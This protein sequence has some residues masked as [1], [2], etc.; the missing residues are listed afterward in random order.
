MNSAAG[1]STQLQREVRFGDVRFDFYVCRGEGSRLEL[2]SRLATL[3]ADRFVLVVDE[4]LPAAAVA[5]VESNLGAIAPTL[6]VTVA[7]HEQTKRLATIDA[8]AERAILAGVTRRSCIV[9]LGGGVVGNMAGLLAGL[10]YRGVRL[11]HLPTT[12]LAMSDSVLSAKQAVNSREG[13]NH[14]G[15]F[16]PPVL[17]WNQLELLDSLP[18]EEIQSALC[19]LIKNVLCICPDRYDEVAVRLRPDACYPA[20]VIIDFIELCVD[21]KLTVMR[22]DPWEKHHA[23]VLEYGHT[24]GH[25]AEL[26]SGGS[27]RHGFAIGIGMLAAARISHL[28]GYLSKSDE[29]AHRVMLERNGAPTTLPRTL[30]LDELLRTVR[31]DNKRGYRRARPGACDFILLD[32]LGKPHC[33]EGGLVSQVDEVVAREAIESVMARASPKREA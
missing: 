16:H 15:M 3:D 22:H 26:L 20:D 31:F 1:V 32:A 9:A 30:D 7:S 13:K 18:P 27:L 4:R 10:L 8:L 12:L 14:L 19:E 29:A 25:A 2:R 5:D 11:V 23:L 28:L 17:V 21:A 33:E 6:A 24:V